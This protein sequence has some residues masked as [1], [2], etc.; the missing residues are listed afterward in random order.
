[1]TTQ[2]LIMWA[3]ALATAAPN[4]ETHLLETARLAA[5]A[6]CQIAAHLGAIEVDL[7]SI[8]NNLHNRTTK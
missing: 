7:D 5:A 1:M 2:E 3:D 6:L 4:S 8:D